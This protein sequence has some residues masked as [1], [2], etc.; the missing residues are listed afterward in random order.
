MI[1]I[2]LVSKMARSGRSSAPAAT[3]R[4]PTRS[5]G[6]VRERLPDLNLRAEE[7]PDQAARR[8]ESGSTGTTMT[9]VKSYSSSAAARR[10]R[11]RARLPRRTCARRKEPAGAVR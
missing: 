10:G 7:Q 3:D 1:L 4:M 2:D 5:V 9:R 6:A 8:R 11:G